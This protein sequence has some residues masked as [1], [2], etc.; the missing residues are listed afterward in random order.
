MDG[1][2]FIGRFTSHRDQF[3]CKNCGSIFWGSYTSG[4]M[5]GDNKDHLQC[6]IYDGVA[7]KRAIGEYNR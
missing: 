7:K 1:N 2:T 6:I 5:S 4:M 3:Y